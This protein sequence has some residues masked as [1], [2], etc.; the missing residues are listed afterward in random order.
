MMI[1]SDKEFM[2]V[3][4]FDVVIA[5]VVIAFAIKYLREGDE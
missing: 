3:M 2:T 4:V 5:L 1:M